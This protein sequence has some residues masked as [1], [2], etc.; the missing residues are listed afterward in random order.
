MF[1]AVPDVER[2]L[3]NVMPGVDGKPPY[4]RLDSP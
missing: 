2:V 1:G 3:V 4:A